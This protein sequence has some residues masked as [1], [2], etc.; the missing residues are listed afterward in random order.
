M[1][2]IKSKVI[3]AAAVLTLAGGLG[4]VANTWTASAATPACGGSCINIYPREYAAT[5]IGGAPQ[6]VT[7]VLRQGARVNQPIILFR[8]A[9]FDPAE[10][11]TYTNQA[12]VSDFYASG[13]VSASVALRYGCVQGPGDHEFPVC[14]STSV[15]DQAYQLQYTPYGVD[16]GLCVGTG[17]TAVAGTPVALEPCGVS[18]KT[19]WIEDTNPGD[20]PLPPFYFAAI[21][22]SSTN[23]SNPPVLTYPSGYPTDKPRVQ[24]RTE[25]LT[26]FSAS[27]NNDSQMWTGYGGVLP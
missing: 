19:V 27:I 26:G 11:F 12:P 18:A 13:L 1:S 3:A 5:S 22:A 17:S 10:D 21:A 24:L 16:S 4:A 7:D 8:S 9:N 2:S 6:F 20:N 15:N 25:N 23:F 14:P